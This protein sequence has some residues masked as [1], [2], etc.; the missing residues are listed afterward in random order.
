MNATTRQLSGAEARALLRTALRN[1]DKAS[2]VLAGRMVNT[3]TMNDLRTALGDLGVDVNLL[4][5][6]AQSLP[7]P[8]PQPLPLPES[9][10]GWPQDTETLQETTPEPEPEPDAEGQ[11]IEA[12][13]QDV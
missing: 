9:T 12:E 2:N 8:Q 5:Q 4:L 6:S 13:L 7:A 3:L 10:A 11:A 1:H